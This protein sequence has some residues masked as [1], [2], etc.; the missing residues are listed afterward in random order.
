MKI[1]SCAVKGRGDV[2]M[3]LGLNGIGSEIQYT[4]WGFEVWFCPVEIIANLGH[5]DR[6][7]EED[8]LCY[9]KGRTVLS[10]S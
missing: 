2:S 8:D 1:T 9:Y 6:N 10:I 4:C 5:N 3:E 7:G